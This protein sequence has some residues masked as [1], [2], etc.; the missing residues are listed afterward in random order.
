MKSS[1]NSKDRKSHHVQ[2]F[3]EERRVTGC[4]LLPATDT[5]DVIQQLTLVGDDRLLQTIISLYGFELSYSGDL[6]IDKC[7]PLQLDAKLKKK[8]GKI[9]KVIFSSG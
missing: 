2:E 1:K 5:E 4:F 3:L 6:F 9:G 8:A 7:G